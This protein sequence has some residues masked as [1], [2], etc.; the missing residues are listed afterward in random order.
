VAENFAGAAT[1]LH[2]NK[3]L[4]MNH[5]RATYWLMAWVGVQLVLHFTL[6]VVPALR[7]G[8]PSF[9]AYYTASWLMVRGE[10]SAQAYDNTW[11]AAQV[12]IAMQEPNVREVIAPNLPTVGFAMLPLVGLPPDV[13]K[14]LFTGVS[15][16]ASWLALAIVVWQTRLRT[17]GIAEW[18]W[19]VGGSLLG[20][21]A[22]FVAN[23]WIGQIYGLLFLALV[24]MWRWLV[25]HRNLGAGMVLGVAFMLKSTG[26]LLFL[27]PLIY[28][29]WGF[30]VGVGLS[31]LGLGVASLV[32][33]HPQT[34]LAYVEAVGLAS[35]RP[36]VAVTAYQTTLGMLSHFLRYD[37]EWNPFPLVD[38]PGLVRP[39]YIAITV[40]AVTFTCW[41]LYRTNAPITLGVGLL[42]LLSVISVPFAEEY[43]FILLLLPLLVIGERAW[44]IMGRERLILW[45]LLGVIGVFLWLPLP[46]EHPRLSVGWWAWLAYPRLYGAWLLWGVGCYVVNKGIEN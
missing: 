6:V 41:L 1:H 3:N 23:L 39:L 13:A 35:N 8:V 42:G 20:W 24:V 31:I 25:R 26:S 29:R 44:A 16:G 11:F 4:L 34:W 38:M 37:A 27:L 10:F 40:F 12:P 2:T 33:I 28:R 21:S 46:Y 45:L 15:W 30:W 18:G 36:W 14:I 9:S 43:H 32:W 5:S 17:G 22:P 19:L 7:G